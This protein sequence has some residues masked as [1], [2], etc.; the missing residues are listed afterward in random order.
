MID[1]RVDFMGQDGAEG[2]VASYVQAQQRLDPGFLRP[3]VNTK[4]GKTYVTIYKGGDPKKADSYKQLSVNQTGTLRR[5]EWKLLDEAII[6]IAEH[7]L[8]GTSDLISRGL[9]YNLGNAMGTT[10]LETHDV[11]DALDAELTM[12]GVTRAQGDR[13]TFGTHYLPIPI[14]H[15]DYEINARAL[16]A[17]RNL[18]NPLDT[19][20]AERAARKVAEKLEKMLFTDKTYQWGGGKINSLVNYPNRNQM[21]IGTNWTDLEDDSNGSVG[22]KIVRQMLRV[23]QTSIDNHF[24]GPWVVYIPT[25]Y[26]TLLDEDYNSFKN[27]TIR[28]RILDIAGINGIIVVDTLAANNILMV[29]TTTDVIRIVRGMGLQTVQW[30][31]EGN[32]ITKYKVLTIQV[33][34]IRS[35]QTGKTGIVH[36]A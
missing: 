13:P 34:Q 20:M 7:R 36:V 27:N 15:A 17:S 9:V 33:P 21:A 22:E 2:E 8:Q 28:Q 16:A 31:T 24:Y 14:I 12:D 19:I 11:S 25:N 30:G 6:G 23:K 35:D 4:D 32:F 26:E 1:T 29:Q 10:V 18:G 3:Y 5:D